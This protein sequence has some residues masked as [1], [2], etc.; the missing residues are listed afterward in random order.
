MDERNLWLVSLN[1]EMEAVSN[2]ILNV[3]SRHVKEAV[4]MIN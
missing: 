2:G 4:T 3:Y 1:C